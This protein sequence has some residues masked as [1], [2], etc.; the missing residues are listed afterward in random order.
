MLAHTEQPDIGHLGNG[1]GENIV[2]CLSG[3]QG[4]HEKI[5]AMSMG[6]QGQADRDEP[7]DLR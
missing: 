1:P 3:R 6:S 5:C 2:V 4:L 7:F